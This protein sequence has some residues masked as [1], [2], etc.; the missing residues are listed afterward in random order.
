MNYPVMNSE[1]IKAYVA[2]HFRYEKQCDL[3]CFEAAVNF[4]ELSDVLVVTDAR[5]LY[6]IE[7]KISITDLK[8]DVDK[9]KHTA[10]R[11]GLS[12]YDTGG[13]YFP[14][15]TFI[16]KQPV[17]RFYFAVP[18]EIWVPA[19]E[20]I[21]RLYPYAGLLSVHGGY[22]DHK[23]Q[24]KL[25]HNNKLS[26]KTIVSLTKEQSGTLCRI[27][28]ALVSSNQIAAERWEELK[29]L[30]QNEK[31]HKAIIA[32]YE[33]KNIENKEVLDGIT[34]SESDS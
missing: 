19:E 30:R 9:R 33:S 29:T 13:R 6:E 25:I 23:K 17:N 26:F 28:R 31:L 3:I 7:V 24:A 10:F 1:E 27:S 16:H 14:P 5:R 32:N 18:Q 22:V 34:K 20:I 21:E 4:G 8:R 15:G 2:G 12:S 11:D